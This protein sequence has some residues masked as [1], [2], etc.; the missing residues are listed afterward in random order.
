VC[1]VHCPMSG[2][3]G[4]DLRAWKRPYDW[5][6]ESHRTEAVAERDTQSAT[7]PVVLF[8]GRYVDGHSRDTAYGTYEGTGLEP[9]SPQGSPC[10]GFHMFILSAGVPVYISIS[11][12]YHPRQR[13][14]LHLRLEG[15][16]LS[17]HLTVDAS[18]VPRGP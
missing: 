2:G 3:A 18:R 13:S 6:F 15:H 14:I 8:A 9:S 7:S 1:G 10:K 12:R 11:C 16:R 5:W 4:L 17:A